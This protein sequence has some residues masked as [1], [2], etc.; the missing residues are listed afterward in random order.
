MSQSFYSEKFNIIDSTLPSSL[1]N[2][3]LLN[4]L[5]ILLAVI[6]LALSALVSIRLPIGP[7]PITAQSLTVLLIGS[8][9]GSKRALIATLTYLIVGTLGLPVFAAST[10][11][12]SQ[13]SGPTGGYLIGFVVASFVMGYFTELQRERTLRGALFVFSLG[14]LIIFGIGLIWLTNFVGSARVLEVGLYPFI[15]GMILKT[16]VTA[17][18]I[19]G[20]RG[21]L[22]KLTPSKGREG[23]E[24]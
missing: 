22:D 8:L 24:S 17:L 10:A 1:Q 11:G 19:K 15:P 18:I 20:L 4:F 23:P 9:Y 12:W 3:H 13:L 14:H 21:L 2:S 7:V 16:I 5:L 6:F